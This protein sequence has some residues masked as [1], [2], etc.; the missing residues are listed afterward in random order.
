MS[1]AV[2]FPPETRNQPI[3]GVYIQSV[4][5]IVRMRASASYHVLGVDQSRWMAHEVR[6]TA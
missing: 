3:N 5:I 4:S 1:C 6:E 2:V